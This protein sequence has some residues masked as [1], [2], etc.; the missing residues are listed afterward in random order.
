MQ[1]SI[2]IPVYNEAVH[3]GGL[4]HYL[5]AHAS[6]VSL[7]IIVVDAASTDDTTAKAIAAG[8]RVLKSPQKGRAAQMNYGASM[9]AGDIL[10]FVH[11]DTRPPVSFAA[12]IIQAFQSGFHLGRYFTKFD[13]PKWI[14]KINAWFT[15][16]DWFICMGGDNTL[17]VSRQV[18]EQSGG[19]K[20]EMI[21]MEEYEFCD[22]L[23]K[24][25]VAYKIMPRSA[26]VSA[27]KYDG[28]SWWQVQMA[29]RKVVAM[30]KKG[31]S[32]AEMAG[33]YKR[34]LHKK[35]P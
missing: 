7:E 17:F 4:V 12:D 20:S 16:L 13:S 26:L 30:Y 24:Q 22:R 21:I 14:L 25:G 27:R 1:I 15:R 32:Q 28:R 5:L 19:F 10:Y 3:I 18:F 33:T 2:I 31:A 34:M 11:A 23:R 9:S 8:A 6:G 35:S 29:N